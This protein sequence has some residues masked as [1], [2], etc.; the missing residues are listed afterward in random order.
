MEISERRVTIQN[1]LTIFNPSPIESA[2]GENGSALEVIN[3]KAWAK[4]SL[5]NSGEF[6]GAT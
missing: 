2:M 3:I 5:A 4:N 6:Y 1:I